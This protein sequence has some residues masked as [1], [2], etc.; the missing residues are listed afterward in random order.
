MAFHKGLDEWTPLAEIEGIM[1]PSKSTTAPGALGSRKG[2]VMGIGAGVLVAI[3]GM[4]AFLMLGGGGPRSGE[5]QAE[6]KEAGE[7]DQEQSGGEYFVADREQLLD[8]LRQ[9]KAGATV[10]VRE[11]SEIDLTGLRE[12]VIPGGVTLAG[13]RVRGRVKGALLFSNEDKETNGESERF[14][15]LRTGGPNVHITGLRLRGPDPEKREPAYRYLNS[16]AIEGYDDG[17][18]IDN[19][20]IWGWSHAG[21]HVVEGKGVEI[22]DNYIHHC[23]RAGLGYGVLVD[24][25]EVHIEANLFDH[26]RRAIALTGRTPNRCT[27]NDNTVGE[28]MFGAE[29]NPTPSPIGGG[30]NYHRPIDRGDYLVQTREQLLAALRQAKAGQT[31]FVSASNAIDLT[32]QRWLEIPG[33]VTLASDRGLNGSPGALI[34]SS[35]DKPT[36][37]KA[38]RFALFATGGPDVRITGI[39]L[40]GPDPNVR[41]RY[42]HLNSDGLESRHDRLEVDNCEISGWSHGGIYINVGTGVYIHH[43]YIHHCRRAGL[44]YCVVLNVAEVKIEANIFDHYRHA[45]AAT[46]RARSGYEACFN[47]A[48]SGATGHVFD[49]HGGGDRKDGTDIAGDWMKIHHNTFLASKPA[50]VI[51]GRPTKECVIYQNW[52]RRAESESRAVDQKGNTRIYRN[53]YTAAKVLK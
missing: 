24:R 52:F 19:C 51:R 8:A 33:G 7:T 47:L 25:A 15:L 31:V 49:M 42:E 20:E 14:T 32:G 45:I 27:A 35:E 4:V 50:V 40:R 34:F 13:G 53:R 12:I 43:N 5:P 17:L 28:G 37:D 39:R 18:K 22:R 46:G 10:H 30:K 2:L 48:K 21:I 38:E 29:A 26:Y 23:Q 36:R 6:S 44:G 16:N 1:V 41:G 11:S 3:V 9:A